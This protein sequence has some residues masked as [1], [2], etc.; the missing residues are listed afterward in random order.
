MH[1]VRRRIGDEPG[2]APLMMNRQ[3]TRDETDANR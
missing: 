2:A 1:P 3:R